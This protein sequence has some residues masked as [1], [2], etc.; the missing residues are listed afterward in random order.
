MPNASHYQATASVCDRAEKA[1]CPVSSL[2]HPSV[3]PLE[4]PL[5]LSPGDTFVS[6]VTVGR[7]R[8]D[9]MVVRTP[10]LTAGIDLAE[11]LRDTVVERLQPGDVVAI[12]EKVVVVTMGRGIPAS[13]VRPG[14]LA[15]F[16]ARHIRPIGDSRGLSIPEKMQ[17]VIDMVGSW[18]V[19]LAGAVAAATR[20]LGIHGPF[21][22]VAGYI[23]RSMDGMRPPYGDVL[24]PPL[25]PRTAR[26]IAEK[27]VTEIGHP[28]AIVDINDRGGSVRAVA[29]PAMSKRRLAAVLADNPLGQRDQ[30]TPIVVVHRAG[31]Q[32][33]RRPLVTSGRRHQ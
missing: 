25:S 5:A 4:L 27:L 31:H 23:A 11:L 12:T 21:F 24:L 18:R 9:R 15:R 30:G 32:G 22:V 14:R 8:Y 16:A 7:E 17:L 6:S 20:P 33:E 2:L 1:G 26:S 19:V 3:R 13:M 29:G 28:V 10:W